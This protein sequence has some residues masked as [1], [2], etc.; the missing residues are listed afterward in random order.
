MKMYKVMTVA[1][2]AIGLASC[3][4]TD[5]EVPTI[6]DADNLTGLPSVMFDEIEVDAGTSV[7]VQDAFCDDTDLGE[8]RWDLHSA[9]GHEHEEGEEEGFVLNS[10]TDWAV[11][12]TRAVSGTKAEE[13]FA[14]DVPLEARGVWDLVVSVVDAEGNA[15]PD[16]ITLLHVENDHIPEFSLQTVDGVDPASWEGEPM[17]APGA[18]V[19]VQGTVG[20]SDGISEAE[21][22]LIRESDETVVWSEPLVASGDT[23][24]S[25][26]VQV[27]VPADAEVGEYHFEMEATDGTGVE[28]HTGFHVEV[29]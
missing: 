4:T 8:I 14:F 16:V 12:E 23:L 18:Q 10:G 2:A 17:W 5:T 19:A 6:C 21:V 22:L 26:S 20:D 27:A 28:M 15:A 9:E 29:E 11:L 25:F 13:Q 3:G 7:V 1:A 24:V